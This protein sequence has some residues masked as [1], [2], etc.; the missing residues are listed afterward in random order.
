MV[1]SPPAT[2]ASLS[3][4]PEKPTKVR[5][6]VLVV[7]FLAAV[8]LYLDRFCMNFAQQYVKEDLGLTNEQIGHCMAGFFFAYAIFQVPTGWLTDRYGP[9][10]ML[11]IYIVVW[12]LFTALMGIV[13][14]FM[15]LLLVRIASGIGQAG[16]Y[17]TC[18]SVIRRWMPLSARGKAS[19]AIAF[20]GRVGGALAPI[21]TAALV[22]ACVPMSVSPLLTEADLLDLAP[23][24]KVLAAPAHDEQSKQ[25]ESGQRSQLARTVLTTGALQ[26]ESSPSEVVANLNQLVEGPLIAS[27]EQLRGFGLEKEGERLL[28][29]EQLSA[30]EQQRANRLILEAIIPEVVRKLYVQGW[31]AVMLMYGLLGIPM[32]L[33]FWWVVRDTPQQHPRTNAA[34]RAL[35]PPLGESAG[36]GREP[37]PL[38]KMLTSRSL[39]MLSIAQFLGVMGWTFLV[40]WLPRYLQEVHQVPFETRSVMLSIPLWC[41]W[42]GM[43]FGGW[44]T[45]AL[46]RRFGLQWGRVLP[47]AIARIASGCCFIYVALF[48]PTAWPALIAFALIAVFVDSGS[49]AV[50]AVH[51]DIGGK[52]T[53]AVLG[54]GNMWGNF[55]SGV[56]LYVITSLVD[57]Y[58]NW[59]FAFLAFGIC[60]LLAG[61]MAFLVDVE[62]RISD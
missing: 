31:R 29:R 10:V 52:F 32:A 2:E 48:H 22:I 12:S 50:W 11:T 33:L 4:A 13:A 46:T 17:P 45:D 25:T 8:L 9:R 56:S 49:S 30:I 39:W 57:R 35:P 62:D 44:F 5:F 34:E 42:F 27:L 28:R 1:D 14:G 58:Q 53:A 26:A 41:G 16:A 47:M 59:D 24:Q 3:P 19:S 54:W 60:F 18:A 43:L 38:R 6:H 36:R 51:Q 15:G 61:G 37:L 21:L 20:G 55:G 23:L 40:T 7:C